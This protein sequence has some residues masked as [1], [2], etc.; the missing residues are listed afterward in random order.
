MWSFIKKLFTK[1]KE[2]V[3]PKF[4]IDFSDIKFNF[5]LK[6]IC[7]FEKLADKSFFEMLDD[8]ICLL[9]YSIYIVSNPEKPMKKEIFF[10]MM[11]R[12]DIA[13]WMVRKYTS[14]SGV[15]E[16][17]KQKEIQNETNKSEDKPIARI[18]DY[19]T[20]LVVEYG[21]DIHYVNY[22][23][24]IWEITEYFEAIDTKVKKDALDKRFWSYIGIMP[25]ID[26]KKC[27][28]PEYLVPYEWE[29][30]NIRHK[31]EKELNNNMY[32]IKNMIGTNIFGKKVEKDG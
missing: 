25:H 21:V 28:G 13:R 29:K 30:E 14:I 4:K 9:L 32:A 17:F 2:D 3:K 11:E 7:T 12:E 24:D 16:Q 23:M 19:I 6:A 18:T 1:T 26:T 10:A 8:D 5:N 20:T 15:I 31:Q 27:K 22:E